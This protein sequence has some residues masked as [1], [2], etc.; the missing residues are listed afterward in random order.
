MSTNYYKTEQAIHFGGGEP[1]IYA[2]YYVSGSSDSCSLT[3]FGSVEARDQFEKAIASLIAPVHHSR[4]AAAAAMS[5]GA[6]TEGERD[7][8]HELLCSE[9]EHEGLDPHS[10]ELMGAIEQRYQDALDL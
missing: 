1:A 10:D 3:P 2:G 8:G 5:H 6:D 4:I 9:L 7:W